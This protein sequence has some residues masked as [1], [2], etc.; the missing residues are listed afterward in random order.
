MAD[1]TKKETYIKKIALEMVFNQNRTLTVKS[2]T[3]R[4][5]SDLMQVGRYDMFAD[6][7]IEKENE[8][9]ASV[10]ETLKGLVDKGILSEVGSKVHNG[11]EYVD[12]TQFIPLVTLK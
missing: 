7:S 2:V 4:I 9:K 11:Y 5:L 6:N 10:K 1:L 12:S 8:I 3:K